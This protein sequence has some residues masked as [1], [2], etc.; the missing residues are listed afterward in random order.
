MIQKNSLLQVSDVCGVDIVR[1]FHVYKKKKNFIGSV[2]N[3]IKVSVR[4]IHKN[5]FK[6]KK[7]KFRSIIVN[8]NKFFKKKDGANFFLIKNSCVL[9]KKRLT[10]CGKLMRGL[11]LYNMNR[12]KFI[13]SFSYI[14]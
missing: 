11:V 7:K 10:P 1:C 8:T 14:L 9:L 12:K 13:K 2:G 6:L 4:S 3:F 5:K